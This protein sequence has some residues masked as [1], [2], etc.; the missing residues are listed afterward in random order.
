[1]MQ[2]AYP[3]QLIRPRR[4]IFVSTGKRRIEKIVDFVPLGVN[5]FINMGFGDLLP[6]GSIDDKANSNNGDIVKIMAT[7]IDILRHFTN[8]YPNA[9]IYFEGS[10]KERTKLYDRILRTYYP[11][12]NKNFDIAGIVE[13]DDDIQIVQYERSANKTYIAFIIKRIL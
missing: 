13:I 9:Q 6:D 10:T 12:F 3:F 5:N 8:Q 11:I 2:A 7:V 4:Y 1:M